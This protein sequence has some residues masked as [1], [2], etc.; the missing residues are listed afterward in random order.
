MGK[1]KPLEEITE[2]EV[3]RQV[4][5]VIAGT[6]L[7]I[8]RINAGGPGRFKSAE[9]GTLDFEGYDNHGRHVAL[10]AKR[11]VGGRLAPHQKARIDDINAKGGLAAVVHSGPEALSFLVNN[12]CL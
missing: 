9:A 12:G 10:E 2:A 11:P 3:S 7:A 5:A 6:G 1:Q 8:Q 4:K